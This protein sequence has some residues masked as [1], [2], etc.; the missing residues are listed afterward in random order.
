MVLFRYCTQAPCS[1]KF[2]N[3]GE[4]LCLS[5]IH[6]LRSVFPVWRKSL[7]HTSLQRTAKVI[8]IILK[9]RKV[10]FGLYSNHV[11]KTVDAL[12]AEDPGQPQAE[13]A[14]VLNAAFQEEEDEPSNSQTEEKLPCPTGDQPLA[15]SSEL[16]F[17]PL[18]FFFFFKACS[19]S[20]P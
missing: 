4:F 11:S 16:N 5:L 13:D 7:P 18:F 14:E 8:Q 17:L 10:S 3:D 9:R 1:I 20:H 6:L 2:W 12:S 15:L 19:R